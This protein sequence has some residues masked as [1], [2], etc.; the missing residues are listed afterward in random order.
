VCRPMGVRRK[1]SRIPPSGSVVK[2]CARAASVEEEGSA[3]ET[4]GEERGGAV[5]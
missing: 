4:G 5:Q 2:I 3:V 1:R